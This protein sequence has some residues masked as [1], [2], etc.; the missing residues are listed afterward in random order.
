MPIP[1][2]WFFSSV[3]GWLSPDDPSIHLSSQP[4]IHITRLTPWPEQPCSLSE[5]QTFL[6]RGH[7]SQRPQLHAFYK[8]KWKSL[9]GEGG[10]LGIMQRVLMHGEKTCPLLN[11]SNRWWHSAMLKCVFWIHLKGQVTLEKLIHLLQAWV[12]HMQNMLN[13]N[14]FI[15]K[16]NRCKN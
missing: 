14:H 1:G 15:A 10:W 11:Y 7:V 5:R 3:K 13:R 4:L 2:A 8:V 6:N 9:P 16:V 12:S